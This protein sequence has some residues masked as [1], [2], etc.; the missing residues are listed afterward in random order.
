[1]RYEYTHRLVEHVGCLIAK[2]QDIRLSVSSTP[3]GSGTGA[4]G[5]VQ[6]SLVGPTGFTEATFKLYKFDDQNTVI[7]SQ[8]ST[9]PYD[10]VT[11]FNLPKGDYV[12]KAEASLL[13]PRPIRPPI[14]IRTTLI[15]LPA[16]RWVPLI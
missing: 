14:G 13:V 1:M 10:G 11:F 16:S 3:A 9:R 12:V 15:C 6:A 2:A 7:Q 5:G 8:R 4:S